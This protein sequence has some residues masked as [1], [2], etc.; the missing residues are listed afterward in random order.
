MSARYSI[1]ISIGPVSLVCRLCVCVFLQS[2]LCDFF[3]PFRHSV[4]ATFG[5]TRQGQARPVILNISHATVHTQSGAS[6]RHVTT[7]RHV[8]L[9]PCLLERFVPSWQVEKVYQTS[10]QLIEGRM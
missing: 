2:Y 4:L 6:E 3:L 7:S 10:G 1:F 9:E 5:S 8:Q